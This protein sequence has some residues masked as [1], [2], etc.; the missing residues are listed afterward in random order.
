MK[1][2]V[3]VRQN[4]S[5]WKRYEDCL[6]QIKEQSPD[7]L[8]DIYID[9]TN[10]LSFA[11]SHYPNS[12]IHFYLNNLSAKVHQYINRKKKENFS[13]IFT[14]WKTEVPQVMYDARKELLYSFLIFVASMIIGIYSTAYDKDFPRLIMGDH[15]VD[16]TLQN[17]A[18]GKPMGVYARTNESVM[19][20]GITINNVRVSFFAFVSGILTSIATAYLLISNGIMVG[21]FQYFFYEQGLLRESFL[22]VWLHGTLEISAII[23]AGAAGI[24]MGNGWLFPGTYTRM[25]SFRR[26]AKRGAKIVVGTI[27]VFVT[28][29][30]IESFVTRHTGLPDGIRLTI[31][32]LSLFFVIFYYICYPRMINIQH[33]Y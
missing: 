2:V 27:P 10:D 14:Y 1:E 13:R 21:C 5:K 3:F 6:R 19:F 16:M 22:A 31:I 23:V 18:D 4:R 33:N 20:W 29:G 28:A 15:Y 32:G 12:R 7:A 9:L 26:S 30:F 25:E 17:I 11:Q 8:A 24:A